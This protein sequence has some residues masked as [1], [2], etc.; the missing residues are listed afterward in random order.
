MKASYLCINSCVMCIKCCL[1]VLHNASL[2]LI[3][4]TATHQNS[5]SAIWAAWRGKFFQLAEQQQAL[6]CRSHLINT[7]ICLLVKHVL[8]V[9]DK[10]QLNRQRQDG[11]SLNILTFMGFCR[12]S[13]LYENRVSFLFHL[14]SCCRPKYG[15]LLPFSSPPGGTDVIRQG[16]N[17]VCTDVCM[18]R[19]TM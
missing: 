5:V 3:K 8:R 11:Q 12:D 14:R 17:I 1:Y 4:Q 16:L 6:Y 15:L 10:S 7:T 9:W 2:H 19:C 18:W 13:I